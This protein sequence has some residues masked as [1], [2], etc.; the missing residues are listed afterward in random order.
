[1]Q[2]GRC[3]PFQKLILSLLVSNML[4]STTVRNDFWWMDV[5][6]GGETK[7]SAAASSTPVCFEM[8]PIS[9]P[10][11][12]TISL[13]EWHECLG[14][15]SDRVVVS[16]LQQ[17]VL[18]FNPKRWQAF[19]CNICAKSKSTHQLA[20]A[21]TD[22]PKYKPLDLL[23]LDVMGPF[24]KDAQG[25]RYLLTVWDHVLMFSIVYPL[26]LQSDAPAAI[27]DAIN[28]VRVR[29]KVAPRALRTDKACEFTSTSFVDSLVKLGVSFCPSLPYS[30]QENSEVECLNRTLGDMARAMLTQS[31]MPT[32]FWQFAYESACFIHNRIP[33]SRCPNSSPYQELYG[34]PPSIT[35]L[36]PFGTNTLVHIPAVNQRHKLDARAIGC[37]LLKPLLSSGCLL[38]EPSTNKMVQSASFIFPQFQL[39]NVPLESSNKGSLR[40]IFNAML[41]GE[42]PME[43]YFKSENQAIDLIIMAKDVSIPTHLGKALSGAYQENLRAACQAE[44]DQM[45][46]RERNLDGTVEKFKACLV[47]RGDRQQPGIN[48]TKTYTP[49]ASLMSLCLLIGTAV[50]KVLSLKKALYG[51]RQAGRCWW[52]FLCGCPLLP[53]GYTS[54]IPSAISNFRNALCTELDI[55]W[56]D[57]LTQ[58]VGLECAIGEGEVGMT[59]KHLT[60]GILEAYPWQLIRRDAP[61]P[62]LP[63]GGIAPTVKTLDPTPFRLVIGLLAYLVS[64]TRPDLALTLNYLAH[65]S[66][67]PT[68]EHWELLDHVIGWGGYLER[69]QTG[70]IIK[71]G[72]APISVVALSTCAA[73]YVALSG[74]TQHF[75]QAINQFTQ[76]TGHFDKSIFCDNQAA[77]QVAINNKSRKRM[78][79]LDRAFFFVKDTI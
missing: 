42:V 52:K 5:V 78:Q 35:T 54:N 22:I 27:L 20:K 63:V 43:K 10:D 4:V 26:K 75:V 69:S 37:K 48:C 73:E 72:E 40:H 36:Y 77:V 2:G 66:M 29:T 39:S 33:N 76:L 56:L 61:L 45:A 21:F 16:F 71:L 17:H 59:Q 79:Y 62:V 11:S 23:V 74:L 58:I 3:A 32:C 65:H 68:T 64:G 34:Q 50:L 55:K 51:M 30:P 70:F 1:M 53:Y 67:A 46:T 47:A 38:W 49:T 41:L 7:V 60:E 14:H 18:S 19:Y 31:R 9:F 13:R 25:F 57:K 6:P 15:A 8:N 12:K 44:L 28:K 24:T